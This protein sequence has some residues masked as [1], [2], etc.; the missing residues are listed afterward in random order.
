MPQHIKDSFV[1]ITVKHLYAVRSMAYKCLLDYAVL[2][3]LY[4][5]CIEIGAVCLSDFTDAKAYISL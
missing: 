4:G 5:D 1:N 2:C 3:G